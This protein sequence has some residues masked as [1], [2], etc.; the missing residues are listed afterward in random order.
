MNAGS[1]K[2]GD[3]DIVK[4]VNDLKAAVLDAAGNTYQINGITYDDGSSIGD[5]VKTLVNAA[6]IERR[7]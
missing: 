4:A 1:Y 3:G 5:A 6:R 7:I 2:Y